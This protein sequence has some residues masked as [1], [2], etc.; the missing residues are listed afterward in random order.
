MAMS[1]SERKNQADPGACY[2]MRPENRNGINK[3]LV[4]VAIMFL[5]LAILAI[6]AS[7]CSS[8]EEYHPWIHEQPSENEIIAS[9]KTFINDLNEP[10]F[11]KNNGDPDIVEIWYFEIYRPGYVEQY[12]VFE[13]IL[14]FGIQDDHNNREDNAYYYTTLTHDEDENETLYFHAKPLGPYSGRDDLDS[15]LESFIIRKP[16]ESDLI[17][18]YEVEVSVL[19]PLQPENNGWP[20]SPG[21]IAAFLAFVAINITVYKFKTNKKTG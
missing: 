4:T 5:Y 11:S 1:K 21:I 9:I 8:C 19:S 2:K 14:C 12:D 7:A 13:Y 20:G 3:S 17:N 6:P 10:P 15:Y 18:K 16:L